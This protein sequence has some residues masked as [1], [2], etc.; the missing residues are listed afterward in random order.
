MPGNRRMW[1]GVGQTLENP[2]LMRRVVL[3]RRH[4]RGSD[5]AR[6]GQR[7]RMIGREGLTI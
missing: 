5:E 4:Q 6:F 2:E 3:V 7:G 1:L